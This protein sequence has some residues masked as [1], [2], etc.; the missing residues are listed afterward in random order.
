MYND[1]RFFAIDDVTN[2]SYF[3]MDHLL[4]YYDHALFRQ[5]QPVRKRIA[6]D[7]V[8]LAKAE[9]LQGD[10]CVFKRLRAAWRNGEMNF[11][12]RKI[13][14]EVMDWELRSSLDS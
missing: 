1:F 5:E 13:L 2:G 11:R 14:Q 10:Q 12:S 9:E 6:R 3:G 8:N 4:E 7:F